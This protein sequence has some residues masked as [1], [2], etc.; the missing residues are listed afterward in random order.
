VPAGGDIGLE[1]TKLDEALQFVS[2]TAIDEEIGSQR[3]CC[4]ERLR[5]SNALTAYGEDDIGVNIPGGEP[6]A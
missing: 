4:L 3:A 6:G 2:D 1:G 5:R